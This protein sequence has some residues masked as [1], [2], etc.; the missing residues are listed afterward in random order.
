[1]TG[2]I[3]GSV[4]WQAVQHATD[5]ATTLPTTDWKKVLSWKSGGESTEKSRFTQ[6]SWEAFQHAPDKATTLPTTDCPGKGRE[7]EG[8]IRVNLIILQ[9]D[10]IAL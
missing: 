1:M 8:G 5:K 2:P 6:K 7:E 10:P 3:S 9:L 4:C